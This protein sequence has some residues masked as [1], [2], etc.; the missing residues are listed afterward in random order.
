MKKI[1]TLLADGFEE[2]EALTP[3]DYL[4]RAGAEVTIAATGTSSQTVEGAHA[5]RVAADITLDAYISSGKEL[6]DAVVIP[7]G[8]PGA[9]NISE[10]AA[11]M[12]FLN[13]MFQENRLIAAICASPAVVLGKTD[14][15]KNKKWTCYPGMEK[16]VPAVF[17]ATFM[18]LPAVADGNL[19]TGRGPGAAEQFSMEIV[20]A[21]FGEETKEKIMSA[22]VQRK[23]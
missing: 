15:L 17:Q 19:I 1:I 11:A 22:S 3:V 18:E 20:S 6:P 5:I 9:K 14:I 2:I 16:E 10:C 4:R 8:M 21:L 13:R 7:G 23:S 12:S